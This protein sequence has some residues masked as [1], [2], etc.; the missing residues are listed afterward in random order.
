[1]KFHWMDRG[2]N[3]Q[4]APLSKLSDKLDSV[5]YESLLL[6]YHAKM[7]DHWIKAA[8]VLNT[9][10]KIKYMPAIRTYAITPE[11]ASM[12]A[13]AFKEISPNRLALNIVSGDIHL[14][15]HSV[16]NMVWFGKDL[17][18]P[19]QRLEYT[20]AWMEKFVELCGDNLPVIIMGGHADKTKRMADKYDATHLAML[21][22]YLNEYKNENFYRNKK[23]MVALCVVIRNTESE[24]KEF[25]DK[26]ADGWNNNWTISGN[27]DTVKEK[28]MDLA[29]IGITD[30]I[31]NAHPNDDQIDLVHNTIGELI[32]SNN[33]V[34]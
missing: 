12:M 21:D 23:Q 32:R 18:T 6:V 26:P 34:S 3:S 28:L 10:H 11:Y 25:L 8:R 13:R 5:G 31:V 15:E 16:E 9:D 20:D 17:A 7:R 33:G 30:I 2:D 4:L 24:L 29:N 27:P 14:D 19:E 22:M 1:M